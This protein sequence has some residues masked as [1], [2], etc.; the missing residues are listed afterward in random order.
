MRPTEEFFSVCMVVPYP[1][2]VSISGAYF[3]PLFPGGLLQRKC[4][5]RLLCQVTFALVIDFLLEIPSCVGRC[6]LF[7]NFRSNSSSFPVVR[8]VFSCEVFPRKPAGHC[9]YRGFLLQST[10]YTALLSIRPFSSYSQDLQI[11]VN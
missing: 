3:F 6:K 11:S 5:T 10:F 8:A 1:V 9:G 4:R 2:F 7:P